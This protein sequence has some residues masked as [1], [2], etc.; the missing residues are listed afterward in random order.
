MLEI[1]FTLFNE[2]FQMCY[3]YR[4]CS[5]LLLLNMT[6]HVGH[7]VSGKQKL[8]GS[9]FFAVLLWSRKQIWYDD[10]VMSFE[11]FGVTRLYA[12]EIKELSMSASKSFKVGLCL[13]IYSQISL[14]LWHL[15]SQEW[16][17][18]LDS[19]ENDLDL[20]GHRSNKKQ[21]CSAQSIKQFSINLDEKQGIAGTDW[22][23]GAVTHV[24]LYK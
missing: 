9:S 19:S 8:L 2:F 17:L 12:R 7:K 20:Q 11:H 6:I 4:L 14:I 5:I 3:D 16:I 21:N 15:D 10:E 13:D 18:W 23:T 22:S 24:I 1:T